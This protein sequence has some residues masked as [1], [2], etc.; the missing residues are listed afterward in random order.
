MGPSIYGTLG[1]PGPPRAAPAFTNERQNRFAASAP[2]GAAVFNRSGGLARRLRRLGGAGDQPR[3]RA[4]R[5][6]LAAEGA[7]HITGARGG[8]AA[9][10]E[11]GA[12]DDHLAGGI[13]HDFV[14]REFHDPPSCEDRQT[15]REFATPPAGAPGRSSWT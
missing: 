6:A 11:A 12:Y 15:T 7:D 9:G 10:G 5:L 1:R 2:T 14:I 8:G 4:L 13:A 3:Q